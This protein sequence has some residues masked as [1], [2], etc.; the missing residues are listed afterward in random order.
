MYFY[1]IYFQV[2]IFV[3]PCCSASTK[4]QP[5]GFFLF[6]AFFFATDHTVCGEKMG[7]VTC[8]TRTLSGQLVSA[9]WLHKFQ[10]ALGGYNNEKQDFFWLC[11]VVCRLRGL[12]GLCMSPV[13]GA[14]GR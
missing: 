3:Y 6:F 9:M 12:K 7:Q 10:L 11:F 13:N 2:F 4:M 5:G 1:F 14:N 8:C